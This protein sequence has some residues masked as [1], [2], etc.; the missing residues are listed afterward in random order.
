MKQLIECV[1]NFSEGRDMEI[2]K[3][4]TAEVER[5]ANVKL[6]DVDPG[7]TTNRTVVTFV[8]EPQDVCEA[9]FWVIKKAK[10]K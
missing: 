9:A 7:A 3:A 2:I 5:V 4:I 1:P 6:L 8:G 10:E